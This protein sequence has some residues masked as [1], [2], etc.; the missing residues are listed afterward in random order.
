MNNKL[1]ELN[2]A[3]DTYNSAHSDYIDTVRDSNA[4]WETT[5]DAWDAYKVVCSAYDS[6]NSD[7]QYDGCESM[8]TAAKTI[9][10]L[11]RR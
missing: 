2:A 3:R 9:N 1:E 6:D 4:A 7:N 8:F 11:L 5:S 10:G